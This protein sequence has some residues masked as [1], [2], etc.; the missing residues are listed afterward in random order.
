[1]IQT[2]TVPIPRT[3]IAYDTADDAERFPVGTGSSQGDAVS[4]YFE[5]CLEIDPD[6]ANESLEFARFL[7]D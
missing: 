3:W 2:E 7:Q 4:T 5:N 6:Y 1:M